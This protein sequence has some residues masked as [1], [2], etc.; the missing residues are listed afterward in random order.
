M[1]EPEALATAKERAWREVAA[2]DQAL[3]AGTLD[4][5]GWHA[6]ILSLIE[7][8]YL[9]GD[10]PRAQSGYGGDAERWRG[11]RGLLLDALPAAGGTFLD[12]GCANGHLMRTLTDWAAE[13]GIAIEPYG[14][15]ISERLADLARD[16]HP[17]W[18]DRIWAAN[19]FDWQP[20]RRFEIV[21]SGLDYVPSEFR[22]DF[23][24]HLLDEVVAPGGRLIIGAFNEETD[25]SVLENQVTDLGYTVA[26]RT[27]A[28]HRHPAVSYKAFWLDVLI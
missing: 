24:R 21:R 7:P 18:A 10:D 27:R 23:L 3:T 8:A 6:A 16:Q 4:R 19:A 5:Q 25:Q 20:P 9:A 11:A 22:G 14:V 2:I 26:G 28:P 1:T 13:S 12:V 15:E 17:Q